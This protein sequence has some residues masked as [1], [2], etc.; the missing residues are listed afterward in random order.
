MDA[1]YILRIVLRAR[2]EMAAAL[3]RARAEIEAFSKSARGAQGDLDGLNKS[4]TSMNTRLGNL[5]K[6]IRGVKDDLRALVNDEHEAERTSRALS[7]AQTRK[8]DAFAKADAANRRY[9]ESLRKATV[10]Q[11]QHA[12]ASRSEEGAAFRRLEAAAAEVEQLEHVR[13]EADRVAEATAREAREADNLDRTHRRNVSSG[14]TFTTVLNRLAGAHDET[15]RASNRSSTSTDRHSNAL[16]RSGS[17]AREAESSMGGLAGWLDN[18][19]KSLARN[20][21]GVARFDN[22]LRGMLVLAVLAFAEQLNTVLLGLAGTLVSVGSSALMAGGA[23]GGALAA[24]IAQALPAVGILVATFSRVANVFKAV[25]QQQLAQRQESVRGDKAQSQQANRADQVANAN[26]SLRNSLEGVTQAHQRVTQAQRDLTDSQRQLTKAR[27]DAQRQLEDLIDAEQRATLAAKGAAL[28]Q[29]DA[30]EQLR[31]AV[32]QGASQLEISQRELAVQQARQDTHGA[33]VDLTR[34]RQD[35][36]AASAG[37]AGTPTDTVR[38]AEQRVSDA[39]RGIDQA[40]RGVV[41]A[42]RAVTRARRGV[43]DAKRSADAAGKSMLGAAG[44]LQFMLSQMSPAERR[45]YQ[46]VQRLR[47]T[48]RQN[49]RGITDY[50]VDAFTHGVNRVNQLLSDRR[51]LNSARQLSIGMAGQLKRLTDFFTAPP[52]INQWLRITAQLRGNL[53]PLGTIARNLGKAFMNI[54]ESAGPAFHRL[55]LFIRDLTDHVVKFTGNRAKMTHFFNEAE[56]HLEAWLKLI[57]AV[58]KLFAALTGAAAPSGLKSVNSMTKSIN[59]AAKYVDNHRA[60]FAKFFEDARKVMGQVWGVLVA[61]GK[62]MVKSFNPSHTKGFADFLVHV[63]VPA[64]GTAMRTIGSLTALFTKFLSLPIVGHLAKYVIAFAIFSKVVHGV[65]GIM[66]TMFSRMGR[67]VNA[68]TGLPGKISGAGQAFFGFS[69]KVRGAGQAMQNYT[70]RFGPLNKAVN[71]AGS[72]LTSLGTKMTRTGAAVGGTEAAMGGLSAATLGIVG[73]VALVVAG[74]ALLITHFHAWGKVLDPIKAAWKGVVGAL[75]KP[76]DEIS[77]AFGGTGVH[78]KSLHDAFQKLKPVVDILAKV[79]GFLAG[80]VITRLA[81][82]IVFVVNLIANFV[83]AI[84]NVVKGFNDIIHGRWKQGFSEIGKG[85]LAGLLAPLKAIWSTVKFVFTNFINGVKKLFGISSPSSVF[86]DIGESIVD[87]LKAALKAVVSVFTWPFR[88]AWQGVKKI[89]N[90]IVSGVRAEIR[91]MVRIIHTVLSVVDNYFINPFRKAWKWIKDRFSDFVGW[92]KNGVTRIVSA[93]ATLGGRVWHAITTGFDR[94][95]NWFKRLPGRL[96]GFAKDAASAV[97][98]AF[99]DVGSKIISGIVHGMKDLGGFAKDIANAFIGLLNAILPDHIPIPGAPD[100]PL[101]KNPIPEL[102]TGG[103]VGGGYGGGDRVPALLEEGE[104]VWTKE[105]VRKAGGHPVM[106]FLRWLLGSGGMTRGGPF[107]YQRG[108]AVH[109]GTAAKAA[110]ADAGDAGAL[111]KALEKLLD[112]TSDNARKTWSGMWKNIANVTDKFSDTASKRIN[113]LR[114]QVNKSF[115]R[116]ASDA[117]AM[118]NSFQ[119]TFES[120]DNVVYTGI[121]YVS[122]SA[123]EALHGVGAKAVKFSVDKPKGLGKAIGG[124]IGNAGERGRDLVNTWLGRGEVVLNWAQQQAVNAKMHGQDT[125]QTVIPRVNSYHAGTPE[126]SPGL[127]TG[128]AG[129]NSHWTRLIAAANRVSAKNWPYHW[130]GGHEQPAHFEPFDC[131]GAVSYVVQQA[132]YKVPTTVSG[133]IGSWRFPRG[134]GDVTVFYNGGHTFMRIGNRYFGTSGFARPNGGAGWFDR[135]PGAG[136]LH[137]FQAVHL[138]D[139]HATGDFGGAADVVKPKIK[140]PAPLQTLAQKTVDSVRSKISAYVSKKIAEMDPGGGQW[141]DLGAGAGGKRVF[142]FFKHQGF[143]NEGAAAMIGNFMQESGLHPTANQPGGPGR[144]IAQ[145]SEGARWDQLLAWARGKHKDPMALET[146]LN[147]VIHEMSTGYRN[148]LSALRRSHN[149]SALT[150]LVAHDY[151]GAGIIGD[152]LGPARQALHRFGGSFKQGGEVHGNE[153]DPV[154][155]LAHAGEWILNR[156]QQSRLAKMLGLSSAGLKSMLGFHGGPAGFQGGGEVI[157]LREWNK[158]QGKHA[159]HRLPWARWEDLLTRMTTGA[160]G[161]LIR[162]TEREISKAKVGGVTAKEKARIA[163]WKKL[164]TMAREQFTQMPTVLPVTL[165]GLV[166]TAQKF[167]HG[168]DVLT[169]ESHEKIKKGKKLVDRVSSSAFFKRFEQT[170]DNLIRDG[171]VIAQMETVRQAAEAARTRATTFL[172]YHVGRR[173]H[174]TLATRKHESP[175]Q[176]AVRIANDTVTSQREGLKD[177]VG[178]ES[179]ISKALKAVKRQLAAAKRKGDAEA[180]K[181]LSA[182]R[183][184]LEQQYATIRDAHAQAIQSIFEAQVAAQQAAVDEISKRYEKQSA[185]NEIWRRIATAVGNADAVRAINASQRDILANQANE[186][187]GRIK[188]AR[189]AGA[190]DLAEQLEGQVA[191]LRTQIFEGLQQDI[192]DATQIIN[193]KASRRMGQLDLF[194]RMADALGAVGLNQGVSIRGQTLSRASVFAERDK[195]L[196]T[197]REGLQNLLRDVQTNP[198]TAGNLKAIQDLTDQLAELDV[199]MAENTK[200]LFQARVDEVNARADYSLSIND[201]NKQII[202]LTGQISGNTDQAA[203]LAS[204]QERQSIL[205]QQGNDLT[206]LLNDAISRGDIQATQDLTKAVL[207]NRVAQLENT[208]AVNDLTGATSQPSSWSTSSWQWFREAIFS[209]MGNVLPQY[210]V[211]VAQTGGLAAKSGLYHLEAGELI[212]NPDRSNVQTT[213]EGDI[214]LTINEAGRP[215]D[216]TEIVGAVSFAR[217]HLRASPGVMPV[218]SQN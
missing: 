142:D 181:R 103:P 18:L 3:A 38:Q 44:A 207:E 203:L 108:D 66:S 201:L 102:A 85:I 12:R 49:I 213:Q 189:A 147:F 71:S 16:R 64:L 146:Q 14:N 19:G 170:I 53:A 2:D 171:G 157:D 200:A 138:P 28:S 215:V 46:A 89:A 87:G 76:L 187:E 20:G 188:A 52:Q 129:D 61:L 206:A 145:W 179:V 88:M 161:D 135:Q 1:E 155:V 81:A 153:G 118:R 8:A 191:D 184:T 11:E 45:L 57:G 156:F 149:L 104:H 15:T 164:I 168:L 186:L 205:V 123:N 152:R 67:L 39:R 63:V 4:I 185:G 159:H 9:E 30:Q 126:T 25:Q 160:L 112:D 115:D 148:V 197:Q 119:S 218:N 84:R 172:Q 83:K 98:G 90:L 128:G 212:V 78:I 151:E 139:I 58:I 36:A 162:D 41:D 97:V 43:E 56:K 21:E 47:Q 133:S 62:E 122:T 55:I 6:R 176:Q 79:I 40:K 72:G 140:G 217:K 131:S 169:K 173:G 204:A 99:K 111:L 192:A 183:T 80:Q 74:I 54:A 180:I 190:T 165:E 60:K 31:L 65:T 198:A 35:R 116:M 117:K 96:A 105:E 29:K 158:I 110:H 195:A 211:P 137:G 127:A 210:T 5:G 166:N 13:N 150:A 141:G 130:G 95:F 26:D 23:I 51:I 202:D 178:E 124:W 106:R 144:G 199:Q 143:T 209:G 48:F 92:V 163:S 27:V 32:Q 109:R 132:G 208:K 75:K 50:M 93:I 33:R 121:H 70:G 107:G 114:N 175:Q 68:F 37:G 216:I 194:G 17:A 82:P 69:L 154:G 167:F 100:I 94:V 10:A 34:A 136:Y 174:V 73:V 22:Q 196:G 134:P 177:I 113:Q 59:D 214:H 101:P 42:E 91:G 193:D 77:K 86:R 7:D 24:G 182:Q 120:L 125:L